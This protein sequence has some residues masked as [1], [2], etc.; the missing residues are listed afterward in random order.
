MQHRTLKCLEST[1]SPRTPV[2]KRLDHFDASL[3]DKVTFML[4][5]LLWI[6][7]QKSTRQLQRECEHIRNSCKITHELDFKIRITKVKLC[8]SQTSWSVL[9]GFRTWC[10]NFVDCKRHNSSCGKVKSKKFGAFSFVDAILDRLSY[11]VIMCPN[12]MII[13]NTKKTFGHT[14]TMCMDNEVVWKF[15]GLGSFI[16]EEQ[17]AKEK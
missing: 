10:K 5:A 12:I 3:A 13:Q 11:W 1:T 4:L 8:Q 14:P 15:I 6:H 16:G 7:V 9:Q 17:I 2:I